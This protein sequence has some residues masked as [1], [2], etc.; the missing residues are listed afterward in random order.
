MDKI[1]HRIESMFSEFMD[2][3]QGSRS[4]HTQE[5]QDFFDFE[6]GFCAKALL[7]HIHDEHLN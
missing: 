6:P 1:I 2:I 5:T 4:L 7:A 3:H